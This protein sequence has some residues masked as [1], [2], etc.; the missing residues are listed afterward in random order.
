MVGSRTYA[1]TLTGETPLLLHNGAFDW[2]PII[3]K[4]RKD[5]ANKALQAKG[6][7][8]SPAWTWISRLY[9]GG[10]K[11][12]MDADNLMTVLR[13]G[14]ARLST[15]KGTKTFKAQTQSGLVVDQLFWPL[16]VNGQEIPYAPIEAL[17]AEND[18]EK[19]CEA[20]QQMGFTLFAKRAQV[21]MSK[22]I[23]VRPRFDNWS[24]AGTITVFDDQITTEVLAEILTQ[25]GRYS[26]IG[27]WRPSSKT[28]GSYGRFSSEI[29]QV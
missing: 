1:V 4:W 15:G 12:V 17:I 25:A 9:T 29:K 22:N 23:R 14:G 24:I 20:V 27:D 10:G 18:Y 16:L 8:R 13:E 26:G 3:A 21:K 28:P 7:D 11:V 6:D 2:D 5:P 19:H